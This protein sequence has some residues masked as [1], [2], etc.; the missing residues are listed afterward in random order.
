VQVGE[1]LRRGQ[2]IKASAAMDIWQ[3]GVLLCEV[4]SGSSFWPVGAT[5]AEILDGLA[6]PGGMPHE[7]DPAKLDAIVRG[8]GSLAAQKQIITRMLD[9]NPA[10]RPTAAD[11]HQE[12]ASVPNVTMQ[13]HTVTGWQPEAIVI[14]SRQ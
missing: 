10:N 9:R 5:D 6:T 4:Y 11:F 13:G 12:R 8:H 14:G 7:R 3:M 1:A 2:P